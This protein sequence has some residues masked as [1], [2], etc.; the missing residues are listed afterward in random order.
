MYMNEHQNK[1]LTAS[2]IFTTPGKRK[3]RLRIS[4]FTKTEL[5]RKN[6]R[7]SY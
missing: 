1:C 3:S 6:I 4:M 7:L 5:H 2:S